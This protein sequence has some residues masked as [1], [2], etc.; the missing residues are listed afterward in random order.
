[1]GHSSRGLRWAD[2]RAKLAGIERTGSRSV[3]DLDRP[4]PTFA[5]AGAAMAPTWIDL[6]REP[7]LQL[8]AAQ[9]SPSASEITV[10]ADRI[11]LQHR[12]MQ[13]LVALVRAKGGIVSRD[14]LVAS[15]WG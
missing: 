2:E 11:R 9:V 13:V 12:V 5:D 7:D 15:C 14:A 6:A 4:E 10:G 3:T 8:G 1:M